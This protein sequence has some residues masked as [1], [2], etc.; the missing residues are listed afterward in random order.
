M[1]IPVKKTRQSD[2]FCLRAFV[3]DGSAQAWIELIYIYQKHG[4]LVNE[5]R[6]LSTA[7]WRIKSLTAQLLSTRTSGP[8]TLRSISKIV[9]LLTNWCGNVT[10]TLVSGQPRIFLFFFL[11]LKSFKKSKMLSFVKI[12]QSS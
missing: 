9:F 6:F 8:K 4:P 5:E 1:E 3:S 11:K 7:S 12:S 2:F 10:V